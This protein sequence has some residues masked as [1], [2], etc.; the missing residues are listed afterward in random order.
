M[1]HKSSIE[2]IENVKNILDKINQI[3]IILNYVIKILLKVNIKYL[4][5]EVAYLSK[6]DVINTIKNYNINQNLKI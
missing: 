3:L 1:L 6:K 5:E 4:M 2:K